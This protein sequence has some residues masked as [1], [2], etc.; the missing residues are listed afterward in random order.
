MTKKVRFFSLLV[1]SLLSALSLLAEEKQ[2]LYFGWKVPQFLRGWQVPV[3]KLE[4]DL[5]FDGLGINPILELQRNGKTV[6][7]FMTQARIKDASA[8][9]LDKKD[10]APWIDA[11][12]KLK[13]TRFKHNFI[14][15]TTSTMS[16]DWF[17]D[18][19]WQ[20]ALNHFRMCAYLAKE[21][22]CV[23]IA[24]DVEAYPTTTDAPF[25]FRPLTKEPLEKVRAQV[26]KRG[27]EWILA[28]AEEYPNME[29][30][31]FHWLSICH[32]NTRNSSFFL[33][34]DFI[35]GI[36]DGLP[37][38]IVIHDGNE[39]PGYRAI[40]PAE[41][42]KIV[43]DYYHHTF[44]LVAPENQSK[45]HA[46]TY[47]ATSLYLDSFVEGKRS[48][49]NWERTPN[50]VKA[51][52]EAVT[53][54][55]AHSDKY[56][57]IWGESGTFWPGQH[58]QNYPDWNQKIP[59]V[60]EAIAAGRDRE[61]AVLKYAE[62]A[63]LAYNVRNWTMWLDKKTNSGEIIRESNSILF[64]NITKAEV[65]QTLKRKFNP[66]ERYVCAVKAKVNGEC[67]TPVI[68]AFFRDGANKILMTHKARATFGPV[69]ADGWRQAVLILDIPSAPAISSITF[70][71]NVLGS[72]FGFTPES[73]CRFTDARIQK[74]VYPWDVLP[75]PA[76]AEKKSDKPAQSVEQKSDKPAPPA[77][78]K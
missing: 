35:N 71:C 40:F 41:Y 31:T 21:T 73:W 27:K 45:F 19:A 51:L 9:Q 69:Q 61:G 13:F 75:T 70:G 55:L 66:G 38:G 24:F 53:L 78:K 20:R 49:R 54:T 57:W 34:P 4:Q 46:K 33:L 7:Y 18:A 76:P 30:F 63:N 36:Y 68:D 59:F 29:L 16:A 32:K 15:T 74:V 47:L 62:K 37:D 1:F 10:L 64:K 28:L 25:A 11:F 42:T 6:R 22:G 3:E 52:Q 65:T 58:Y 48:F 12:S 14:Q 72:K 8:V 39:D 67:M 23:G 17:D 44:K 26:R 77:E 60:K 5:P 56:A 2:L 50:R 43:S